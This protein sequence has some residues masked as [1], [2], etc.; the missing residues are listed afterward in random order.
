ML[1]DENPGDVNEYG[2][3]ITYSPR[4]Q[5]KIRQAIFIQGMVRVDGHRRYLFLLGGLFWHFF[6][7]SHTDRIPYKKA[8]LR[9]DGVLTFI[10][11][12][13]QTTD[14]MLRLFEDLRFKT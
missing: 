2:C 12:D 11:N 9:K 3:M 6:V 5:D 7:S 10:K 1:L 8:F 13:D 4:I 14:W